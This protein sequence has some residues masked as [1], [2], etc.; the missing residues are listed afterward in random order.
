MAAVDQAV[1]G[2]GGGEEGSEMSFWRAPCG[3]GGRLRLSCG[4]RGALCSAAGPHLRDS[5][6]RTRVSAAAERT[7]PPDAGDVRLSFYV[8]LP[9]CHYYLVWLSS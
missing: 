8:R 1:G 2:K 4:P 5:P 6:Q 9:A 3:P 7:L